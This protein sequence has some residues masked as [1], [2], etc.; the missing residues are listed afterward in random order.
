M[1]SLIQEYQDESDEYASPLHTEISF[2]TWQKQEKR[3][4]LQEP[5]PKG[6]VNVYLD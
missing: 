3:K 6:A 2:P 4:K 5:A 1:D